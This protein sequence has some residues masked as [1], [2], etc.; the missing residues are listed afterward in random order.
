M[1]FRTEFGKEAEKN[2]LSK[3]GAMHQL[4]FI[5]ME[6][7]QDRDGDKSRIE[8]IINDSKD[9][10]MSYGMMMIEAKQNFLASQPDYLKSTAEAFFKT[11]TDEMKMSVGYD[12][13]VKLD[14]E[15]VKS[16]NILDKD[17]KY[18]EYEDALKGIIMAEN[19]KDK[20]DS[21]VEKIAENKIKD[22]LNNK[23]GIDSF[24][25]KY[26][27]AEKDS[28]ESKFISELNKNIIQTSYSLLG[29]KENIT[30][31]DKL[32]VYK[33]IQTNFDDKLKEMNKLLSD[34]KSFNKDNS[35]LKERI[36]S[37][38]KVIKDLSEKI[39]KQKQMISQYQE[40]K[41]NQN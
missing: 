3:Q 29:N 36:E 33:N 23:L 10:H 41:N 26:E 4:D 39:E 16:I 19:K 40:Q 18:K 6:H 8:N 22:L 37:E 1:K 38:R 34:E 7:V 9:K 2:G 5:R 17:L 12:S 20:T 27:N 11:R 25:Q 35:S 32:L 31:E 21:D 15:N 28:N 14:V 30:N 13:V 24:L